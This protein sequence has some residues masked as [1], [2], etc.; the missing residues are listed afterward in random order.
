MC[1]RSSGLHTS[2]GAIRPIERDRLFAAAVLILGL[3][4]DRYRDD[5]LMIGHWLRWI[6]AG[7]HH[8]AC[9]D[10]RINAA[11]ARIL[12]TSPAFDDGAAIPARHAGL[13][14]GENLSP[15]LEWSGVPAW[16]SELVLVMQDPDAPL[17]RPSVHLIATR[18][19]A[20]CR[21]V[22]EGH[23]AP[24][25]THKIAF[26]CGS[27]GRI[28]YSGPRPIR[29]HGPHR[30]VFQIFALAG[31]LRVPPLADLCVTKTA[32]KGFVLAYGILSGVYDHQ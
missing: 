20:E 18:I 26:G 32:M 31:R 11:S 30:Y 12:L 23:L 19:P 29:G 2:A 4:D 17:P 28:G 6:R 10:P 1:R 8:L 7:D 25:A 13:G 24:S 14:L 27:F 21:A 9:N 5:V 22:G 15:P 3:K 16:T